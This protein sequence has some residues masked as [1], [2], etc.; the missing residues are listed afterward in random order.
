[1][2]PWLPRPWHTEPHYGPKL[3]GERLK[4]VENETPDLSAR[5]N[6]RDAQTLE[7][8]LDC[9]VV[10]HDV[11]AVVHWVEC[12]GTIESAIMRAIAMVIATAIA[13]AIAIAMAI[14]RVCVRVWSS[15]YVCE[16]SLKIKIIKINSKKEREIDR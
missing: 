14:E 3:V 6:I 12:W 5:R 4:G 13:K 7:A 1:M 16:F 2:S 15:E 10:W 8:L 11:H 9:R